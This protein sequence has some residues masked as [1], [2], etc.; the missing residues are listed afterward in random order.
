M[1]GYTLT[2]EVYGLCTVHARISCATGPFGLHDRFH[3][4][5]RPCQHARVHTLPIRGA[6]G[7]QRSVVYELDTPPV[8]Y[9]HNTLRKEERTYLLEYWLVLASR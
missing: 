2:Y 5:P 9:C 6:C 1:I 7:K 3:E 4:S 8:L